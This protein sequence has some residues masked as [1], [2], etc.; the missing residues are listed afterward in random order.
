MFF[1]LRLE[2]RRPF[3]PPLS[4]RAAEA[5][6]LSLFGYQSI[7]EF[8]S[9]ITLACIKTF[10]Y[11]MISFLRHSFLLLL[12]LLLLPLSFFFSPSSSL[13]L[14]LSFFFPLSALRHH[15]SLFP[16]SPPPFWVHL[17]SSHLL[18]SPLPSPLFPLTQTSHPSLRI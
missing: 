11:H 16:H 7:T 15:L 10:H 3:P 1:P 2:R 5:T 4:D 9:E 17:I 12:L 18:F 13:L 8:F 6:L 14:L